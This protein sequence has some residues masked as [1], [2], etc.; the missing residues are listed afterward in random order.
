MKFIT[1]VVG[2]ESEILNEVLAASTLKIVAIDGNNEV[3]FTCPAPD[4]GWTHQSLSTLDI[5]L[6]RLEAADAYLGDEWVG[7]T[8]V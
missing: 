1:D 6:Q 3:L 5:P 7:S 4:G 2:T 8:E